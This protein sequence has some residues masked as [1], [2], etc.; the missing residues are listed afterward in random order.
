MKSIQFKN[1]TKAYDKNVVIRDLNLTIESGERV[2]LL[3]PSGCGKTTTL[4]M[5]SGLEDITSGDLLM[6]GKR[7]NDVESGDRNI[8]MVFQNYALFP[9]M[10]VF[11]NI[12]F[13]LRTYKL[14]KDEVKRRVDDIIRTLELT[15]LEERLPRQLSGGQRQRVALARAAVKKAD[16]FLLDEPLSNLDAQLRMQARKELVKLH[17]MY[18]PTFVYVT[19]DQIEAMTV[20]QKVV[21]MYKGDVQMCDTPYNIY[22]RPANTFTAKFIGSPPMNL[23]PAHLDGRRLLLGE[24]EL[25]LTD[26]WLRQLES[27]QGQDVILGVRPE[28]MTLLESAGEGGLKVGV[29]Y[30]ENYGNKLGVYFDLAGAECIASEEQDVG[31]YPGKEMYWRP[32]YEKL[33]FFDPATEKN[34]GYPQEYCIRKGESLENAETLLGQPK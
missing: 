29:K 5:I 8:A 12:A 33:H 2:I 11:K 15:G 6:G 20:G 28:S 30:V 7:V 14:P 16:Y 4:R 24:A 13:G 9:H 26:P 34:L 32:A 25:P 22:Y 19:H 21:L 1:V 31:A 17:E 3:G 27:H 23:V 10:T 18:N